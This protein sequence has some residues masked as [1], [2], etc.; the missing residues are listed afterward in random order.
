VGRLNVSPVRG[1]AGFPG[2]PKFLEQAFPQLPAS[3]FSGL[4]RRADQQAKRQADIASNA[5]IGGA[6][7]LLFGQ[8]IGAAI[9]GAG[10]GAAGG[11]IGGQFGFGLSLAGTAL[12][13]QFDAILTKAVALGRG[14]ADPIRNFSAIQ[15]AA[16][17]SSRGLERQVES[18]IAV[19]RGAEAAALIQ[20]DLANSYG[21]A[22][23]ARRLADEQDRLSRS[24]TLLSVNLGQF[25]LPA[26]ADAAGDA[27]DALR[28]L[29]SV[30]ERIANLPLPKPQGVPRGIP[31]PLGALNPAGSV[32]NIAGELGRRIIPRQEAKSAQE[33]AAA[34]EAAAR[35]EGQ[36]SDLLSAQLGVISA[37][38][39][40]YKRL[41]AERELELSVL[42]QAADIENL[43]ARSAL[44]PEIEDRQRQGTVERFRLQEQL[45]QL[46]REEQVLQ[47][48]R[49]PILQNQLRL[50]SA[51]TQG[52]ERQALILQRELIQ[53]EAAQQIALR[54][55]DRGRIDDQATRDVARINGQIAALD[56]ERLATL[57]SQNAQFRITT[58]EL[59]RQFAATRRLSQIQTTGGVTILRDNAQFI[60]GIN[61]SI[62]NSLAEQ[63]RIAAEIASARIR[64]GDAADQ[65]IAKLA[66]DQVVAAQQTRNALAEGAA[67]LRA[68]GE[69]LSRDA[70]QAALNLT[71][72]RSDAAGLNQFL[73]PQAQ[74]QRALQDF[75]TLLP[76]FREAQGRF[77]QLTGQRAPDFQGPT[78]GVNE[79]LRNFIASVDREFDAT[80]TLN[81]TTAALDATNKE[82]VNA[83]RELASATAALAAKA[84]NVAVNVQGGSAQ[85]IGDV[86]GAL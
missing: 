31:G 36:R 68:A 8:G 1:G 62:R 82:L 7:P 44:A 67:Q 41:A 86:V 46:I 53:R 9:G 55:G 77:F 35:A 15:E 12:G 74:N 69:Q 6:F 49:G 75:Q 42:Q 2:S 22:E 34:V 25:A 85:A 43:R 27:A 10:G 80:T 66:Q 50:I 78:A 51:Q 48:S 32:L 81:Q 52:F 24:W 18:L 21:G 72:I 60:E 26:T 23:A 13:A 37:Q 64:G 38:T 29:N 39:Q 61:Q 54:P 63:Q 14:L 4:E 17:L 28:G 83:N 70:R 79:A 16:L 11:A 33:T 76:L 84:W 58:T 57:V 3:Y 71:A 40:G 56:R 30:L 65:Q 47:D 20:A 19:G 73:S 45:N 59:D 5:L